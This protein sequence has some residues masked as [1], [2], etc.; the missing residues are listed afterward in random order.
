MKKVFSILFAVMIILTGM[1]VSFATH[2][3]GGEISAVKLSFDHEKAGCGMCN[4]SLAI[5]GTES[6]NSESCCKD[7]ISVYTVDGNYSAST[8]QIQ[9]PVNHLL[10]VFY[11]PSSLGIQ[12]NTTSYSSNTHVQP[13]GKYLASAVNLP[14]IC[15]FLI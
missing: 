15:V 8:I 11:I 9:E 4:E 14:D 10:Q 12:F 6:F 13:P 5:P 1:H 3:C 7:A 2:M